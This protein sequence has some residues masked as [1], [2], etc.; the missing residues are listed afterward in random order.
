MTDVF[1]LKSSFGSP[2]RVR[3][4]TAWPNRAFSQ[5]RPKSTDWPD[6]ANAVMYSSFFRE[7]NYH[8]LVFYK[9]NYKFGK[10]SLQWGLYDFVEKM[11]IENVIARELCDCGNHKLNPSC[12][13][14]WR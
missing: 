3:S 10:S 6:R 2:Q 14:W 12:S 4:Y 1:T 5:F 13:L 9:I 8:L 11:E 7:K